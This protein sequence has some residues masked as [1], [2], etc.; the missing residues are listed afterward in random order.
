MT[1]A[2]HLTVLIAAA[3]VAACSTGPAVAPVMVVTA[4]LLPTAAVETSGL[5]PVSMAGGETVLQ[6]PSA[7]PYP[8]TDFQSE[9]LA[10]TNTAPPPPTFD[11]LS[12]DFGTAT[13]YPTLS[14]RPPPLP[15][16]VS[17]R[18][19]DHFWFSRPIASNAVNWP[20]PYYRYGST[21]FGFMNV[22][23]GVDIDA[24]FGTPVLAAGDGVVVWT[25]MGLLGVRPPEDDP[26]GN[27]VVIKHNFGYDNKDIYTVYA[28]MSEI[29]V[30]PD[31][32]MR[33][34]EQLGKVGSTGFSTGPHLHFEVRITENRFRGTYN[35]ELWLAPPT[36]W[37]VLVGRVLDQ[38][39]N[40]IPELPIEVYDSSGRYY[41]IVSYSTSTRTVNMDPRY[42]ENFVL[43]DL[44]A[45]TYSYAMN[46]NGE[47]YIGV[48][49][50]LAGRS[51][52]VV[53]QEGM[54]RR[55]IPRISDPQATNGRLPTH[56]GTLQPSK[57]PTLRP[58]PVLFPTDTPV[59][60][61]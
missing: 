52:F 7:T 1:Y 43:S 9:N 22:H 60:S 46:I 30:W 41:P 57:T 31:Q 45:G 51:T 47:R 17:I 11:A 5:A 35:P 23:T 58:Q 24:P 16:P 29:N 2:R 33:A 59:A 6:G 26:Y 34:G 40:Y 36:G 50:I 48:T 3:A 13:P 18:P 4:T 54:E 38:N 49:D 37:G 14:W 25:G 61:P 19:E 44:P 15:V 42:Q 8:T 20:H 27:A 39:G 10:P 55:N 53:V 56:T 21:Y 12:F 28:H 32:P